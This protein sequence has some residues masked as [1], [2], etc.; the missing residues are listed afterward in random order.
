M[1]NLTLYPRVL[2]T[3]ASGFVGQHAC[4]SFVNNGNNVIALT[5]REDFPLTHPNLKVSQLS[6]NTDWQALLKDVNINIHL[7]GIAHV[8]H[9]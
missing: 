1:S 8:M 7:A 2:I 6:A 4:N 9:D 5:R 3:G